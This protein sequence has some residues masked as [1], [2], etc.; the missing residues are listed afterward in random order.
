[1]PYSRHSNYYEKRF[2]L[3]LNG[4]L[5]MIRKFLLLTMVSILALTALPGTARANLCVNESFEDGATYPDDWAEWSNYYSTGGD[6]TTAYHVSDGTAR[7]G[8][9]CM[10]AYG[11][12]Y[13]FSYQDHADVVVG[14]EY[15]L[16]AYFKDIYPGGSTAPVQLTFEY[17]DGPRDVAGDAFYKEFYETTIPNDGQW[18]LVQ[19]SYVTP[20]TTELIAICV[21]KGDG[22]GS[23]L[24]DYVWFSDV[25]F[26]EGAAT[27][28]NPSDGAVDIPDED[29][30]LSWS[31]PAFIDDPTYTVYLGTD[32][33]DMPLLPPS[34]LTE[35]TINAGDL[36]LE[37]TYVWRV[38]VIDPNDG[39]PIF[40][41]G[42]VWSFT[43]ASIIPVIVVQ[44][45]EALVSPG[46]TATF[47][48]SGYSANSVP[49]TYAWF[50]ESEPGNILSETDTLIIP[51]AQLDD[52]G[53]YLCTLTNTYGQVTSEPARLII[54]RLISHWPFE[55]SLEDIEGGNDG[56]STKTPV[57][58]DGII[59][60]YAIEFGGPD[61]FEEFKISTDP[62]T[63]SSWTI[64][65]WEKANP[66]RC[67]DRYEIMLGS[68][69]IEV[70]R[71]QMARYWF[72]LGGARV[73][74]PLSNA[75]ERGLWYMLAAT[76]DAAAKHAVLY[77][78]GLPIIEFG[79]NFSGFEDSNLFVGDKQAPDN[80]YYGVIDD[81]KMYNYA[82]DALEVA[83]LYAGLV[84]ETICL[85]NPPTDVSGPEG[86]PDC[87]VNVYDLVELAGAW[88]ECNRVSAGN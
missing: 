59:D 8:E 86:Q 82:M 26:I 41:T 1:M 10:E 3:T 35:T 58:V 56:S 64:S 74:T 11:E 68:D 50:K 51:D 37:T 83:H 48:I 81:L 44:P 12:G 80:P 17:R 71:E 62:Y 39:N 78:N 52:E 57:Y 24:Y 4:G 77:L 47:T 84:D 72:K 40:Y 65:F 55:E 43:T 45:Q 66:T 42:P 38:D 75:Y 53:A 88:L 49:L 87:I 13:A 76:Y 14:K 5:T 32:A 20:A 2:F 23:Y 18:H 33:N 9:D 28:P 21:G 46:E 60:D 69:D 19:M 54:Q 79:V 22:A 63:T 25:P 31:A 30:Q 16:A 70:G 34:G 36:E 29:V 61:L 15:Y 73:V 67:G 85:Q 6:G 27:N 7:T